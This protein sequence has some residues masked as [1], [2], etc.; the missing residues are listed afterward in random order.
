MSCWISYWSSV[1]DPVEVSKYHI[2]SIRNSIYCTRNSIYL[3]RNSIYCFRSYIYSTRSC[4]Y[5]NSSYIYFTRSYIYFTRSYIYCI[6]KCNYNIRQSKTSNHYIK[7]AGIETVAY[8]I[9]TKKQIKLAAIHC[10]NIRRLYQIFNLVKTQNAKVSQALAFLL[11][12]KLIIWK[13]KDSILI[14]GIFLCYAVVL[15]FL[16]IVFTFFYFFLP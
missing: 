14:T 3:T 15:F 16:N 8:F 12:S 5:S 4:I 6:S 9:E 1:T 11:T 7:N 13:I 2:Y 10:N